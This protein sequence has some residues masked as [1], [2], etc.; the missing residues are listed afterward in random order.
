MKLLY[1]TNGINGSGGLERVLAVKASYLAENIG[2]DVH[3]LTLNDGHQ[4]PFYSFS[5][6]IK[7]HDI[8]VL[9]NPV[10]YVVAYKKGIK[11]LL[12]NI[13]PDIISVCDD[14]LKGLLFPVLFGKTIPVIY[15]RHA[16]ID[17]NFISEKNTSK[18]QKVKNYSQ[19]KIMVWGAKKFN[20]FVVLT[21]GNKNDWKGVNCT[22]IPNLSPFVNVDK[23]FKDAKKNIVLAVGTQSYNKGFGRLID[24]WK[25][26]AKKHPDWK[27]E[28]Y[29]K[30]NKNLNLQRK[31]DELSL[32]DSFILNEPTKKIAEKYNESAIFVLPSRSEGFG[33]VLIEAMSFGVPCVA[34]DCPHG[35][36]DIIKDKEDGFLIKD[37]NNLQ[38]SEALINLI[39]NINLRR[40]MGQAAKINVARY[41]PDKIMPIWDSLFKSLIKKDEDSL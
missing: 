24:I 8:K 37:G 14:G 20:L 25:M 21:N 5:T 1:I 3:I 27:L 9:G 12:K 30:Q 16:S 17:L 13:V 36:A 15:E 34:F 32:S 6:A 29:G 7:F 35:P 33:M 4:H 11:K 38:F 10:N 31:I 26:I 22:V 18:I 2:Y 28:V 39:E 40:K 41:S 19:K 23:N